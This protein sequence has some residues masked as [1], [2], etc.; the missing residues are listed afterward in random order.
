[1]TFS[2]LKQWFALSLIYL[3]LAN[4]EPTACISRDTSSKTNQKHTARNRNERNATPST[5]TQYKP[6]FLAAR[7]LV[8]RFVF[9]SSS[10][11]LQ[12]EYI[13]PQVCR[14]STQLHLVDP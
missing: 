8:T 12:V 1:M 5:W 13:T 4:G 9:Q 2:G 11:H 6:G 3:L 7:K 14:R 10:C